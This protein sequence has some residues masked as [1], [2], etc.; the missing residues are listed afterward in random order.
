MVTLKIE[1]E[2]VR[3]DEGEADEET[4]KEIQCSLINATTKPVIYEYSLDADDYPTNESVQTFVTDALTLRGITWD[5][6][7]VVVIQ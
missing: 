6:V 3:Y 7:E 1:I 2:T 5:T 4:I